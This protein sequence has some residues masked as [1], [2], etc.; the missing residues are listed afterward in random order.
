[1]SEPQLDD[2]SWS[3]CVDVAKTEAERIQGLQGRAP[4][5]PTEGLLLVFSVEDELCVHNVG[6]SFSI[7]AVF[8]DQDLQVIEVARGLPPFESESQCVANA[9]YI[10]ELL[11]G[12]ADNIQT[13]DILS[14][15]AIL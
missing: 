2:E 8:L 7:D 1:M 11:A 9:K 6:V 10:L 3:G 13:G 15:D 5:L 4:L 14:T 12:Q